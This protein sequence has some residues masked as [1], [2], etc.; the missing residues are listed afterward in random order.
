MTKLTD[1]I[2]FVILFGSA[3]HPNNK[4]QNH[5]NLH[6][7]KQQTIGP[8]Y[9]DRERRLRCLCGESNTV[10]NDLLSFPGNFYVLPHK[11]LKRHVRFSAEKFFNHSFI[12]FPHHLLKHHVM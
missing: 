4:E 6:F 11:L 7:Q 12:V 10:L 8:S 1:R 2:F 9:C 3:D 5:G